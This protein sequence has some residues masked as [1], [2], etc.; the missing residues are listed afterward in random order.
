MDL[1]KLVLLHSNDM[2]GDFFDE[3]QTDNMVGGLSLLS[4]YIKKCREEFPETV[5]VISGDMLQG[6]IIDTEYKGISTIDL[7]NLLQPDVITIGNH[8]AD[9]GIGHLMFLERC[10]KFPIINANLFI[11]PTGTRLFNSHYILELNGIRMLFIGIITEEVLT[12]GGGDPLLGTFVN[13]EE[14]SREIEVICNSYKDVDVDL[15]IILTHIG[16]EEDIKLAEMINPELGVDLIIG[17]HTHTFLDEPTEVNNILIAQAGVGTDFIGRFDII[18]DMDNNSVHE[19]EWELVPIDDSHCERDLF[20]EE[21]LNKYKSATD[22]KYTQVLTRFRHV[23][24]HEDRYR[25]TALGNLIADICKDQFGVDIFILG[26]GSIRKESLGEIVT[27]SDLKEC[28]PFEDH[29]YAATVSG[30]LLK[31]MLENFWEKYGNQ[32]THEFYQYSEGV[33]CAFDRDTRTLIDLKYKGTPIADEESFVIGLQ[34]FRLNNIEENF[35]V[36]REDLAEFRPVRSI[37]TDITQVVYEY[38]R[39]HNTMDA[40]V[41]GRILMYKDRSSQ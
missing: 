6:S 39:T 23:L 18:I 26:S 13:V 17:G 29:V 5:Y 3:K 21:I 38:F 16:Y 1:R 10:A 27:F 2:H 34:G 37:C 22:E 20:L 24:H 7:M 40:R 4:G 8:E 30:K 33:Q 19:Y 32:E 14:A 25:E 9:Y 28:F 15:T 35:G 12:Q 41:E 36:T 31:R 11:K